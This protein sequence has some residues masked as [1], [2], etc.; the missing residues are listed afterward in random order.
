M[1]ISIE[2]KWAGWHYT[3][4]SWSFLYFEP[5]HCPM[6]YSNCCFLTCIQ[7]S[8]ETGKVVWYSHL[9]KNSL[10]FIVAPRVKVFSAVNET[11]LV[12]F[13]ELTFS[14]IQ[15][16]LAIWSLVP[17]PC[18]NPACKSGSSQF[19]YCWSQAWGMLSITLLACE[20]SATAQ[21]F[22]HSLLLP[23]FGIGMKTDL[24]QSCGHCWVFQ[25]C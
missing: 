4:L 9:F 1:Y 7:V 14:M 10:Q 25:I 8:Q 17:L 5:V 21:Q 6:S 19:T 11:E 16:M 12:V 15:R 3:A 22:E 18:W 2:I 20:M 13:L 24:F 23:F